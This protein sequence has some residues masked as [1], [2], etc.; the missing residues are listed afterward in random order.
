MIPA[1][2]KS[3]VATPVLDAE[4]LA[5]PTSGDGLT[6]S[7][8]AQVQPDGQVIPPHKGRTSKGAPILDDPPAI[9]AEFVMEAVPWVGPSSS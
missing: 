6:Q 9:L 3:L 7:I 8:P 2:A 1:L 5:T 4:A